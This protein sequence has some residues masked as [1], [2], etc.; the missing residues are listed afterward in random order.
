MP[1]MKGKRGRA[2]LEVV[3]APKTKTARTSESLDVVGLFAGIGGIEE[4]LRQA[5]HQTIA[6]CEKD[7][8]AR[9]VLK[10]HFSLNEIDED[11][12]KLEELPEAGICAAGF[13]CQ[14]LSQAGRTAGIRGQNSRLIGKV[15]G[16][17]EH[18]PA[19]RWL[20]LENVPF[21]LAL[22]G[23]SGMDWL[24]SKLEG[25]GYTWAYRIVDTRSFGVPQR[26]RR[27][28]I[29]AS[30]EADPRVPLLAQ[31]AG[32][33]SRPS[34]YAHLPQGFYWTE[35]NTGLGLVIGAIPT[36]KGGSGLGIPSPPAIWRRL[37]RDFVIPH[38]RDAERLQGFAADWTQAA[39]DAGFARRRWKLVGNAVSVPVARWLGERL[40]V[41]GRWDGGEEPF[42]E[43]KLSRRDRW[44]DAAWGRKGERFGVD[45]SDHPVQEEMVWL[46]DFLQH[47]PTPLSVR[48]AAGFYDRLTRSSLNYTQG[49]ANDLD[50]YVKRLQAAKRSG[51]RVAA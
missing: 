15:L 1:N 11:I 28:L 9:A 27:V 33:R 5:G 3:H 20:W 49:F 36:L 16:L 51:L 32:H 41:E 44:P 7:E 6:L 14:D 2:A 13:P 23:G 26:R 42:E 29:L 30:K 25:L 4:G 38:I 19:P 8:A 22:D 46:D 17:L 31:D 47:Q 43:W 48:A 39:E 35:G 24:A 18:S 21:M 40:R 34:P 12:S 50:R 37:E 10:A 45:V